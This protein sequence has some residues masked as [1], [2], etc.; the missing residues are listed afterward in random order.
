MKR[1]E[2]LRDEKG[3]PLKILLEYSPEEFFCP[4]CF[5]MNGKKYKMK[6]I[7]ACFGEEGYECKHCH[8]PIVRYRLE[9]ELDK[10][11]E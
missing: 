7:N 4:Y 8:Y 2:L 1:L 11:L 5:R 6:R 9:Q 3:N 10:I